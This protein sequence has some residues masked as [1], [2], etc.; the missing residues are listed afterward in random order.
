MTTI[1]HLQAYNKPIFHQRNRERPSLPEEG[2]RNKLY[3]AIVTETEQKKIA[4]WE[5]KTESKGHHGSFVTLRNTWKVGR[6]HLH[7]EPDTNILNVYASDLEL[8]AMTYLR[9]V[10][11]DATFKTQV[12]LLPLKKTIDIANSLHV[13]HPRDWTE[14]AAKTMSTDIVMEGTDRQTKERKEIA[15]FVRYYDGLYKVD[16]NGEEKPITREWQKIDIA[17]EYHTKHLGQEFEILTDRELSKSTEYSINWLKEFQPK[18]YTEEQL[19][20]FITIFLRVFRKHP[21]HILDDL[22]ELTAQRLRISF[23]E[24]LNLFRFCG[25]HHYLPLDVSKRITLSST[26]EML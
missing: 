8:R 9:F 1:Q 22:L 18:D 10:Y 11:K 3:Q 17:E 21:V 16:E 23:S 5:R 7:A 20:R 15:V 12:P 19:I 2:Q 13:I 14:H 26:I 24:C 25:T 6:R 4:T